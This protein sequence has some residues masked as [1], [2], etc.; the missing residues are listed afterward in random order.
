MPADKKKA[1]I[2]GGGMFA[3]LCGIV[4]LILAL[5]QAMSSGAMLLAA[6]FALVIALVVVGVLKGQL[7]QAAQQDAAD[8]YLR[9]DSFRLEVDF[10]HFL[11]ETTSRRK[12]ENDTQKK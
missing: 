6:L 12:I 5:M 1:L 7:K 4:A 2:W 11:Y 8:N 9:R 3:G 10:D